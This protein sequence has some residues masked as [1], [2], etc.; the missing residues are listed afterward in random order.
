MEQ[1]TNEQV[2][3]VLKKIEDPDLH[4][5]IVALGFVRNLRISDGKVAFEINLTTPACPVKT[6]MQEEAIKRVRALPGVSEVSVKMT[7]DVRQHKG[8]DTS[9][10]KNVKNIIAVG[11]GKGGVGKS[12]VSVNLAVAL[13]QE[14]ARVG[15]LD[16]DI[17]GPSIPTMMGKS[18]ETT[19][20]EN[21]IQPKTAHGLKFMSMGFFAPGDKPLIW[22]GPMAHRAIEQSLSDV[23]WGELDYLVVDLPPGT[24]DVHLTL[25]QTVPVTG[26][27][28]VSTPQDVGLMISM[29]TLRLFQETRVQIL[30]IIENMSYH[31]CS[32]CGS[33]EE[34]FGHGAVK[35]ASESLGIPF[36]GEIPLNQAIRVRSDEG[37]PIV[38]AEPS[39]PIAHTYREIARNL[40]AQVSI[41]N[42]A[43]PKLEI[44]EE[45]A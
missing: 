13:A 37:Y 16:A 29:K 9:A 31:I 38:L 42:Y 30:G 34:I 2:L 41:S 3:E 26:A 15:L 27:V 32:H 20:R 24:G 43:S 17:Y 36:L 25:V 6:Q 45:P 33:R 40:A 21:L 1:V 35:T 7:A 44:V 4:K 22:R 12:T 23:E 39:S 5:D 11:S 18:G 28:I 14:G 8:L 19:I 10:L